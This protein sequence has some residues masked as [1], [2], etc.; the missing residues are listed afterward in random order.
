M[1]A[2]SRTSNPKRYRWAIGF[3]AASVVWLLAMRKYDHEQRMFWGLWRTSSLLLGIALGWLALASLCAA[4]SRVALFKVVAATLG[5]TLVLLLV[6]VAGWIRD[7][8]RVV[9]SPYGRNSR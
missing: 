2:D 7:H 9:E 8:T 3:A 6:E 4:R 1:P 5:L